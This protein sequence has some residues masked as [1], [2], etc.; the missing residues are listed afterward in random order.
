[1]GKYSNIWAQSLESA[2]TAAL[3]ELERQKVSTIAKG[4]NDNKVWNSS[5]RKKCVDALN[6]IESN[7]KINGSMAVL[8]TKLNNLLLASKKIQTIKAKEA[9]LKKEQDKK[10]EN[11]NQNT[12]NNLKSTIKMLENE[13]DKLLK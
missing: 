10:E 5:S 12:I 4:L 11:R 3:N 7:T 6:S 9:L 1:M 2:C 13:V 8:K